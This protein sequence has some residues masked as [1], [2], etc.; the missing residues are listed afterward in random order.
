MPVPVATSRRRVSPGT[1]PRVKAP[2]MRSRINNESPTFSS[3]IRGVSSPCSTSS[4]KNSSV[5]SC[6]DETI[7]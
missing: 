3:Q 1:G 6:G 2:T 5:G 7:E 4:M